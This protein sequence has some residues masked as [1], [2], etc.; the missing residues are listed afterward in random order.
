MST[1]LVAYGSFCMSTEIIESPQKDTT[2][3]EPV[4]FASLT[5]GATPSLPKDLRKT[6]RNSG[7]IPRDIDAVEAVEA[8]LDRSL[9]SAD[10][11]HIFVGAGRFEV[12]S[13]AE[14]QLWREERRAHGAQT[15]SS[16]E[17]S[18][19]TVTNAIVVGGALE[20]QFFQSLQESSGVKTCR[21]E[22]TQFA[23]GEILPKVGA[24]ARW[25]DVFLVYQSDGVSNDPLVELM[26]QVDAVR[27]ACAS[28]IT[29]VAPS[30]P[31]ARADR[32]NEEG[33]PI[34]A[35]AISRILQSQGVQQFICFDMH[36][37]QVEGFADVP[38]ENFSAMPLLAK[39]IAERHPGEDFIVALPDEGMGKRLKD[40]KTRSIIAENLGPNTTFLQMAK[41]RIEVNEVNSAHIK[42]DRID[43]SGKTVIIFD[44]MIDTGKT[45]R[46]AARALLKAGAHKVIAAATHGIFSGD[47]IESFRQD[48]ELINGELVR[49][50]AEIFVTD[51]I[52]LRRAKSDLIQ[53]VSLAGYLGDV[54]HSLATKDGRA[55]KDIMLTHSGRRIV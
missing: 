36:A 19:P 55:L 37:G 30:F 5:V 12:V 45:T 48:R 42:G 21:A 32:K 3:R 18:P 22:L 52:P 41:D 4:S 54:I 8:K 1:I 31:Y 28:R 51:S 10:F 33:T 49:P 34:S 11:A 13:A 17:P 6:L 53:V 26:L 24:G 39:A 2:P 16:V 38:I 47:A 15:Q 46:L 20:P 29:V 14:A 43:L 25:K 40:D 27:R 50:V 44:D 23:N 7:P 35:A 9:A